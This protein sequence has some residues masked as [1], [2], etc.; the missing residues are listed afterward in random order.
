MPGIT[1]PGYSAQRPLPG[2]PKIVSA[3]IADTGQ[4]FHH[5]FERDLV[6]RIRDEAQEC[7][8]VFDM[9]LLE[10]T[11]PARDLIWNATAR[12]LQLQLDGVVMRAIKHCDVS[13]INIFI[14]QLENSLCDKLSLLAAIVQRDDSRLDRV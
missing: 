9:G 14:S 12:K 5:A 11:D 8:H 2:V 10:K 7:G 6:A 3:A 1:D 13:Q 4:K